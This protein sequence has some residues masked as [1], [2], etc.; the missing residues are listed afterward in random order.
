LALTLTET[1]SA[2]EL[3]DLL[4][5]ETACLIE[6]HDVPAFIDRM[7]ETS[8]F[9]YFQSRIDRFAE[10]ATDD[11][12]DGLTD[13]S[14]S[15]VSGEKLR[16]DQLKSTQQL[17]V[18]WK[19]LASHPRIG[20]ADVADSDSEIVHPH[21]FI[22]STRSLRDEVTVLQSELSTGP[23]QVLCDF[24]NDSLPCV[25][26]VQCFQKDLLTFWATKIDN[27]IVVGMSETAI[28]QIVKGAQSSKGRLSRERQ[29]Q[30]IYKR[31]WR[32]GKPG[33]S[34]YCNMEIQFKKD[35]PLLVDK[36]RMFEMLTWKDCP[37]K[38]PDFRQTIGFDDLRGFCNS[39]S[40]SRD[41]IA[42]AGPCRSNRARL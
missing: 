14:G 36:A 26:R 21:L 3:A 25:L 9:R 12:R 16:S 41:S 2:S 11:F 6:V 4:P 15:E 32:N 39:L 28:E 10:L 19:W 30:D 1:L 40:P 38:Y 18:G 13:E 37:I 20:F 23:F 34:W 31:Y 29:F 22:E 33:V 8:L 24:H 27:W 17:R 7:S 5:K 35:A 42:L